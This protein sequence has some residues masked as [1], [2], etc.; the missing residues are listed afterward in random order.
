MKGV[1]LAGGRGTR[2][3]PITAVINKHLLPVYDRPMLAF[4][5][6][7]LRS[8]EIDEVLVVTGE[9]DVADVRAVL[10]ELPLFGFT[11]VEIA[12]EPDAGGIAAALALAEPFA[13]GDSVLAVLGD[14]VFNASLAP[15][16]HAFATSGLGARVLL[17]RVQDPERFGVAILRDDAIV[18]IEEKP[19]KPA[20]NLAVLG[21]YAYTA[22][23]FETI[24]GLERS[25]RGEFEISSVN[26]R[27]A[28]AGDLGYDEFAPWWVDAGE[29]ETLLEASVRVASE[30]E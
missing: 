9:R 19:T 6:A 24:R 8:A 17:K 14:N 4:P 26:D 18:S 13:A 21:V 11:R 10:A 7:A 12:A 25:E 15:F 16:A 3:R 22:S 5:L 30:R 27:Y 20:S 29:F 23:V 28:R 1:V 2:L